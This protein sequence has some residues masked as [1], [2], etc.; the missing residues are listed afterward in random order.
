MNTYNS[1]EERCHKALKERAI[2]FICSLTERIID[3]KSQQQY[4]CR[5]VKT[6]ENEPGRE[7]RAVAKEKAADLHRGIGICKREQFRGKV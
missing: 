1:R 4:T 7:M 5:P 3:Y 6:E 2:R